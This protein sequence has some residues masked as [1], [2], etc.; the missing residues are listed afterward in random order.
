MYRTLLPLFLFAA[1]AKSPAPPATRLAGAIDFANPEDRS[2]IDSGL[3]EI[4]NK[5]WRWT[6]RKFAVRLAA[7]L[8][9]R[10]AVLKLSGSVPQPV[11]TA[12][13][14]VTL[15][16]SVNGTALPPQK[17]AQP[18]DFIL[19]RDVPP[20]AAAAAVECS[21][22]KVYQPGGDRRELGVIVK[23]IRLDAK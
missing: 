5:S 15:T 13:Q 6:S 19:V 23:S 11:L 22:D 17:Y 2:Q 14:D 20:V 10:G 1:C 4:E 8:G 21:V 3:W 18:G 12:N 16:C 7:P 9:A